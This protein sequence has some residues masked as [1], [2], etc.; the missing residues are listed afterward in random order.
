MDLRIVSL[1]CALL[2]GTSLGIAQ[3][4]KEELRP[5]KGE[6]TIRFV[7]REGKYYIR[8]DTCELDLDADGIALIMNQQNQPA[9]AIFADIDSDGTKE[10]LVQTLFLG[11]G[12]LEII[13]FDGL[14][15]SFMSVLYGVGKSS[16]GITCDGLNVLYV[17]STKSIFVPGG[18][19]AFSTGDEDFVPFKTLCVY[20]WSRE[21]KHLI[22]RGEK[23]FPSIDESDLR[24]YE[25]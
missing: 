18:N 12:S 4:W 3:R 5:G 6:N 15:I 8:V 2:L 20:H 21:L 22:Y 25:F 10:I 19:H 16:D 11:R 1:V 23:L 24:K 13:K 14:K 17:D 7:E 9:D